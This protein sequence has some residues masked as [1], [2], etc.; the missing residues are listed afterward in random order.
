M[1]GWLLFIIMMIGFLLSGPGE[2]SFSSI[3]FSWQLLV[4]CV[5]Y[6]SIFYLNSYVLMPRYF[7]EKKYFIYFLVFILLLALVI[8]LKP[9]DHLAAMN[10]SP[11]RIPMR[12]PGPP[13]NEF[14]FR[15]PGR[16]PERNFDILSVVLFIMTWTLSSVLQFMQCWQRTEQRVKEIEAEKVQAE[17]SF[18]KAQI[19][20]H[21]LFNTLN[22]IYSLAVTKSDN[23]PEAIIKLSDILRYLTEDAGK[24]LVS[25]EHEITC[26]SNY[27]ELQKLRLNTRTTIDYSITGSI[28]G[29]IIPPLILMTFVENVFKYGV[30][31]HE[32]GV[33]RLHLEI[34][35]NRL[36]FFAQ[37]RIVP[38][39][40]EANSTGIGIENARKRLNHLYPHRHQLDII[41]E[42]GLYTV[43]LSI[44]L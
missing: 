7:F 24:Q 8:I 39:L 41:V 1:I 6:M 17:L 33:I 37:N 11:E 5:I 18:L 38:I 30:S 14:G 2:H 32:P 26:I 43:K 25:L 22:N 42:N 19:N 12:R 44:D 10:H 4:F 9:F 3:L 13:P 28:E 23:T 20:P 31:A 27:I 15:R 29:K 36:E 21:F 34:K 35:E 16:R 40:L